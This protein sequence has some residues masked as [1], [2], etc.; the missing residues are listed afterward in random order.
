MTDPLVTVCGAS[1]L[2]LREFGFG[3]REVGAAGDLV[4]ALPADSAETD[5]DLVGADEMKPG[6][7]QGSP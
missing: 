6:V 4:G 5:A 3:F 2:A 1:D 7:S